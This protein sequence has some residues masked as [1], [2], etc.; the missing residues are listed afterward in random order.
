VQR[1]W[2]IARILMQRRPS[3][4]PEHVVVVP[5]IA[6]SH[7][8]ELEE[9]R[10]QQ[11]RTRAVHR[12]TVII[13]D[14]D[15]TL[16]QA[17]VI[18]SHPDE[19]LHSNGSAG[20]LGDTHASV[21]GKSELDLGIEN[22]HRRLEAAQEGLS[23]HSTDGGQQSTGQSS[24]KRPRHEAI[25][26]AVDGRSML[27]DSDSD[28]GDEDDSCT[29]GG[30][31]QFIIVFTQ[32][33]FDCIELVIILASALGI[34]LCIWI[35]VESR[36]PA[37][38]LPGMTLGIMTFLFVLGCVGFLAGLN[39]S[40]TAA[41][42]YFVLSM[43][44]VAALITFG[45]SLL[46]WRHELQDWFSDVISDTM[47]SHWNSTGYAVQYT[48]QCCGLERDEGFNEYC[49]ADAAG[50]CLDVLSDRLGI[51]MYPAA[52]SAYYAAWVLFMLAL[53]ALSIAFVYP[54]EPRDDTAGDIESG[55]PVPK[56]VV[57]ID[58]RPEPAT[59]G[60]EIRPTASASAVASYTHHAKQTSAT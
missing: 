5:G 46:I 32:I 49:P 60:E 48:L 55:P 2:Q 8:R 11:N 35:W 12:N 16:E 39:R 23:T 33:I 54:C 34:S 6:E 20:F 29:E 18:M 21:I 19:I 50:A 36:T 40:R 43:I 44:A 9:A 45:T 41:I 42:L 47:A 26:P 24:Y 3:S 58:R 13:V 56:E 53:F 10:Q 25:T 22:V 14:P 59:Y 30:C 31:S 52:V 1:S 51:F 38:I 15:K 17:Q 4:E 28:S 27:S 57:Y 37:E 7:H